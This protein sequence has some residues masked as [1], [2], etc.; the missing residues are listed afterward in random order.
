MPGRSIYRRGFRLTRWQL[1]LFI[2]LLL[3]A[4]LA[5]WIDTT[6]RPSFNVLARMRVEQLATQAINEAVVKQVAGEL[7]Y[8]ELYAVRTDGQG[9]VVLMQYNT[10]AASRI[11]AQAVLAIQA[12]MRRLETEEIRI[13]LGLLLGIQV[14][15]ARGPEVGV[16]VVPLG[17]VETKMRDVFEAAG[18]NQTRHVVYMDVKTRLR[19]VVPLLGGEMEVLSNVPIAQAIIPGEVPG[20]YLN[21]D[22]SGSKR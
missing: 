11:Q 10:A 8:E 9:R 7:R 17:V 22:G 19:V 4:A 13:P 20:I 14:L 18:I 5:M 21:V 16:T 6:L 15:A 1:R 12:A 2:A 3:L